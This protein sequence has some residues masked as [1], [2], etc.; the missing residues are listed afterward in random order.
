[1]NNIPTQNFIQTIFNE[2]FEDPETY[3]AFG[4]LKSDNSKPVGAEARLTGQALNKG[5]G[6]QTPDAYMNIGCL[7]YTSDAADE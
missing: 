1:M 7:L 3:H 2:S 5:G 4:G 6:A